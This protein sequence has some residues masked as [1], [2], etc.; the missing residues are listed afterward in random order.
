MWNQTPPPGGRR[1]HPSAY[2]LP[3]AIVR[4]GDV[5]KAKNKRREKAGE[6][7]RDG[8][9]KGVHEQCRA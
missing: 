1:L 6:K 2:D 8:A 3:E 4:A 7:C 9:D 5:C